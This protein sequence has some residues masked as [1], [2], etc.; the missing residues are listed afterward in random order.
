MIG[1]I[2]GPLLMA[3]VI[4]LP[5]LLE[6]A[7]GDLERRIGVLDFSGAFFTPLQEALHE[8]G[9]EHIVLQPLA[10]ECTMVEH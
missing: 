7:G 9:A 4:V 2:L 10:V 3:M 1:T 8:R 6:D 5:L